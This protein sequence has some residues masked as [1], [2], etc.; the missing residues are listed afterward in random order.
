MATTATTPA[1]DR[2]T[3]HSTL[4]YEL[5]KAIREVYLRKRA[6]YEVKAKKEDASELWET[7]QAARGK[8]FALENAFNDHIDKHDCKT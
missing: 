6:Y 1:E 4:A 3:E 7:L 8:Q 2:C 5:A